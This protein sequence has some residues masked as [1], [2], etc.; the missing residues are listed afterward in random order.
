MENTLKLYANFKKVILWK[1]TKI[2]PA[3]YKSLTNPQFTLYN[4]F[5]KPGSPVKTKKERF[6]T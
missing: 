4:K 6:Q 5:T 3:L 1:N 2:Y